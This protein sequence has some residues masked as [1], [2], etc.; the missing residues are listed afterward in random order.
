[1]DKSGGSPAR[2]AREIRSWMMLKASTI[3]PVIPKARLSGST[4][5]LAARHGILLDEKFARTMLDDRG[6]TE[7]VV[8]EVHS[9]DKRLFICAA[10]RDR[11]RVDQRAVDQNTTVAR[12]RLENAGKRIGSA[13]G[14]NEG[15]A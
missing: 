7:K 1:M 5:V 13:H 8:V 9:D 15:T 6:T 4:V 14:R 11:N 3:T 12:Y 2:R 10:D